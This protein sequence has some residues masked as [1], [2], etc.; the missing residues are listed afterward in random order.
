MFIGFRVE[1]F[2]GSTRKQV[3]GTPRFFFFDLGV[4]HAA[5]ELATSA[6]TVLAHPGPIFEQWVGIELWKRLRY[7]GQGRLTYLRTKGGLEID[8]IIER[9]NSVTPIEV[10]WTESPSRDDARH[11]IAFLDEQGPRARHGYVVCR[12]PRPQQVE[13]RVTAV[14]WWAI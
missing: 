10:K 2:T 7:L 1:A 5:A 14:P 13:R 8:F 11:L 3:I 4:R 6:D 9:G 12:C